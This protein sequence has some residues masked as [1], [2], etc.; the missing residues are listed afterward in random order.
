MPLNG[1]TDNG[2]KWNQIY[3]PQITLLYLMC[4]SSSFAYCY[5]SVNGIGFCLAQMIPLSGVYCIHRY[6]IYIDR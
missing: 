2:F 4:V 6:L 1:I 3:Q 5:E